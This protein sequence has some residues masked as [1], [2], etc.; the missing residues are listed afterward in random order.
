MAKYACPYCAGFAHTSGAIPNPNEWLLIS[1]EDRDGMQ[2]SINSD[3]LYKQFLHLFKCVSC[4]A[5]AIFWAG[6]SEAPTWYEP[7]HQS[8]NAV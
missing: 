8:K 6:L 4:E 3:E 1:D 2:E 5:I 7:K